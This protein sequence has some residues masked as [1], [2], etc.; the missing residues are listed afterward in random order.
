MS[1]VLVAED[2]AGIRRV[3]CLWLQRQGHEV[4]EAVNGRQALEA[5]LSRPPEVLVTDV[6]MPEMD[7]IELVEA[8]HHDLR[9]PKGIIVLTSRWDHG[10]VGERLA[11]LGVQVLPKPFSPS[12]L[13]D[14]VTAVAAR[15]E[16]PAQEGAS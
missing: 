15:A 10:A 11:P 14:L 12:K 9:P 8:L 4:Q 1:R 6:N 5:F 13:A 7:G 2:D 3:I 16:A